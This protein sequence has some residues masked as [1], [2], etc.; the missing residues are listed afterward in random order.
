MRFL[1]AI[2]AVLVC[3][4][5]C[6][7][8]PPSREEAARVAPRVMQYDANA[9]VSDDD[10]RGGSTITVA[11]VQAFLQAKGSFLA[12]YTDPAYQQTAAQL[13]V[14]RSIASGISPLYTLARIQTESSLI[15]SGSDSY[16][17][18]ATGCA[19]PDGGGCSG[20]YAGFGKQVECSSQIMQGYF[21][22]LDAG[23]ATVAGWS[24][25]V[26]RMTSDPCS[27]TP[28]NKAT[29]ALYT[30]TP[31]VGA[32]AAGCGRSDVGGSSLV[33]LELDRYKVAQGWGGGAPDPCA[34]LSDGFYC[35]GDGISGDKETLYQCAGGQVARAEQ[36][37]AG[38]KFNPPGV[39]DACNPAPTGSSGAGNSAAPGSGASTM[40]GG[41]S[42]VAGG[43]DGAALPLVLLGALVLRR[44]RARGQ[45]HPRR[46]TMGEA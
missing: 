16:L 19:C 38:C 21:A 30:Y 37:S 45:L 15:E 33:A 26:T 41:C 25:G 12:G 13:I 28:A 31:W 22:D 35:D 3:V 27:V 40:S 5:A 1:V 11:E 36:C 46:L 4:A 10:V 32:Y 39:P 7:P 23:R 14:E 6:T 9:L 20:S 43:R 18:A 8:P 24:V 2:V 17:D 29:A 42:L 34:G 44:R